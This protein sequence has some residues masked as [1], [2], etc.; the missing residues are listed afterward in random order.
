V[1]FIKILIVVTSFAALTVRGQTIGF[2]N[3]VNEAIPDGN[4]AGLDS[5]IEVSGLSGQ[6]A[7]VSVQLNV[8]GGY[9]GDLYA[10]LAGPTAGF[11]VLL[12]R[13]GVGSGNTF[14][15]GDTG[16]NVRLSD[17]SGANNIHTYQ[18]GLYN[19]NLAGQ[20]TGTWAADGLTLSPQS[21]PSA[22]DSA[23]PTAG[24]ASF[25]GADPNGVWTLFISDVAG[26]N[27]STLVG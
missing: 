23:T 16:F 26:G 24:L 20:L 9:N 2:T 13:V 10:Y 5:T 27:E 18:I 8:T 12:N 7:D 1:K 25:D 6:V 21:A 19:L 11:A 17:T 4:P 3:S 22:F 14:G 15:Y